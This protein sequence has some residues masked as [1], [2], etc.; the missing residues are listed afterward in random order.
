MVG[1]PA[2]NESQ[3]SISHARA[4][5]QQLPDGAATDLVKGLAKHLIEFA[6]VSVNVPD[7]KILFAQKQFAGPLGALAIASTG[8]MFKV[9]YSKTFVANQGYVNEMIAFVLS[10]AATPP[11]F[12]NS[13]YKELLRFTV[14]GLAR[15]I[16]SQ[17]GNDPGSYEALLESVTDD[18]MV[19]LEPVLSHR[20][21]FV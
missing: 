21:K 13:Q 18:V 14:S 16:M 6:G 20:R 8:A 17:S 4:V 9:K 12:D 11:L 19:A 5:I 2:D 7:D 15:G 3:S 1:I 10:G